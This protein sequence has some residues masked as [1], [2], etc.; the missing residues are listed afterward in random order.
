MAA[1]FGSGRIERIVQALAQCGFDLLAWGTG[2]MLRGQEERRAAAERH[3]VRVELEREEQ[4][5][6][7]VVEERARIAREL[8]E[9]VAHSVSVMVL[10]AGGGR[11]LLG[12]PIPSAS[13][14][15]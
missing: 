5:R 10:Q 1:D 14:R 2:R 13:A 9:A 3:A 12:A 4:A 11:R 7:A 15:R 6:S 8:N